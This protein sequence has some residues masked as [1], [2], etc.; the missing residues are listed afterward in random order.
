MEQSTFLG[1]SF[2]DIVFLGRNK[3]YGAYQLRK[4][5]KKNSGFGLLGAS[6]FAFL[7]I[8]IYLTDF[9]FLKPAAKEEVEIGRAHV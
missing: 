4:E 3:D 9:S 8:G 5:T 1:W 6:V 2:D 7:M